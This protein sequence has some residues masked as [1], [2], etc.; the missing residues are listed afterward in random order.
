MTRTFD[1]MT[2]MPERWALALRLRRRGHTLKAIGERLGVT[3]GRAA[4][5]IRSAKRRA[6]NIAANR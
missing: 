2:E 6:R 5:I 4:Q 3:T 1:Q